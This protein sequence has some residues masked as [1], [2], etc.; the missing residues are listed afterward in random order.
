MIDFT[1]LIKKLLLALIL[2]GSTSVN[3]THVVGGV[4]SYR[5]LTLDRYEVSLFIY[6]D[7]LAGE[8]PFDDP[9]ELFIFESTTGDIFGTIDMHLESFPQV[10]LPA[11]DCGL[12][13]DICIEEG[14]YIDTITLPPIAG[15]YDLGWARCCLGTDI[16]NLIDS[17]SQGMTFITH[18]P[19][20]SLATDN[21]Q[22]EFNDFR[23]PIMCTNDTFWFD[24]SATDVDG[25]SLVYSLE[26]TYGGL[27]M[28]GLGV[29]NGMFGNNDPSVGTGGFGI[30]P[31]LMGPPP[32]IPVNYG[33]PAYWP[34]N[35]FGAGISEIDSSTGLLTLYSPNVGRFIYTIGVSEFRGGIKISEMRMTGLAIVQ[36]G[37]T[38]GLEELK[39]DDSN[40][41]K[42]YPNP[43][44]NMVTI[45]LGDLFLSEEQ[46]WLTDITGQRL[47]VNH[48]RMENS[49]SNLELDLSKLR[50]GIYFLTIK[51]GDKVLTKKILVQ[52]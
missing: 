46:I 48:S 52:D 37:G 26:P 6:R 25:D 51:S 18:V 41:L 36:S 34:G 1:K 30:P 13:W 45:E 42:V 31:N 32:Y 49:D 22:P 43:A 40:E 47:E 4:V 35:L 44:R 12:P 15:G 14:K 50:A 10:S 8:A 28:H 2:I 29:G 19:A 5:W 39:E 24:F 9:V 16:N 11:W 21:S 20:P 3:A 17:Y 38:I 7:C 33:L 23:P 27:N